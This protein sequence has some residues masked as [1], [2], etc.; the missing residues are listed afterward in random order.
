MNSLQRLN[1]LLQG[2]PVDRVP[3]F[4]IFMTR[5]AHHI[6]AP[7]STYYLDQRV[8]CQ[9]N[10]AVWQDFGL[11]ILQAISDPYREAADIGLEVEFPTDGLPLSRKPLLLEPQDLGGLRF[12]LK[13]F[14]RRMTDRLEGV[15]NLRARGGEEV[16]VMGWV[17]GALAEACDLRGM[18]NVMMDLYR[19][20][21]W[22]KEL[23]EAC[24]QVAIAFACAQIEAGAHLVG[25][26]D[27]VASQVSPRMYREFALP[28]EQRIFAAIRA[29]G[30]VGRLHI[31]GNTTHLLKDMA[32]SGAE[33][34][35]IDWMVDMR[36]AVADLPGRLVCGNLDP[37]A[38]FLQGSPE[39]V[40][41]GVRANAEAARPH[42]ISAAG[43][44]IPDGTPAENLH[45]Q[46]QA[47]R[48]LAE[49][50]A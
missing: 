8:L 32:Q 5:A 38:V 23:L 20:P 24:T 47:L 50:V 44:E 15:R 40:R 27:A 3:N 22:L 30:G 11:D 19:R 37:V 7:L 48:E 2:H 46:G 9:A 39:Q 49:P 36:Q 25:L 43:C 1:A 41:L 21:A 10:L 14:G 26:G 13:D 12:P 29:R 45:A 34:V 28:Y 17:E 6:G 18:N 42:W 33:I 16:P 4:D 35:D 31:C